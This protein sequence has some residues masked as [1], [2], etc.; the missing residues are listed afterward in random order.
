MLLEVMMF[1]D[2]PVPSSLL[3]RAVD[4]LNTDPCGAGLS[5]DL[6]DEILGF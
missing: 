6:G 1:S 5:K 4:Q 2:Q 3:L